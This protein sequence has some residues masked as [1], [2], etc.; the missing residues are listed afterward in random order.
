MSTDQVPQGIESTFYEELTRIISIAEAARS[1]EAA[2]LHGSTPTLSDDA[3]GQSAT[4]PFEGTCPTSLTGTSEGLVD[5]ENALSQPSTMSMTPA[6]EAT[7]NFSTPSNSW[8]PQ[9]FPDPSISGITA[10][11]IDQS[12][13]ALLERFD[14]TS[15]H[16]ANPMPNQF[17]AVYIAPENGIY[18]IPASQ[19]HQP[20][21]G[22][23]L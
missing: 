1:Q 10:I 21:Q 14:S 23:S 4:M 5:L 18:S 7:S 22:N 17:H 20:R 13:S 9:P 6:V 16:D 12:P 8:S 3:D 15:S 2:L 19:H 11:T